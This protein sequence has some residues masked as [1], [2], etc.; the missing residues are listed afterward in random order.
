MIQKKFR[1]TVIERKALKVKK[2]GGQSEN[3]LIVVLDLSLIFLTR[4]GGQA[5]F[6]EI[7][8]GIFVKQWKMLIFSVNKLYIKSIKI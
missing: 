6:K 4:S 2:D 3:D 5:V 7:L 8:G 1:V